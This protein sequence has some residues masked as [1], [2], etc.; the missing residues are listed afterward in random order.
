MFDSIAPHGGALKEL[1]VDEARGETLKAESLDFASASLSQRQL[2]DLELLVSGGFSPLDGFMDQET[3][4]SVLDDMRLPGGLLWPIP[5][6][7]DV[8]KKLAE[9]LEPSMR[10]ALRDNE[11]FMLGVLTVKDVWQPDKR[12]EAERVYGTSSERHAGVRFLYEQTQDYY[13]GGVVE[14]FHVATNFEYEALRHTPFELRHL[15]SKM[16]WRN[17]VAFHTSQPMHRLQ[18]ELTVRAAK[19]AQAHILLHPVVGMTKPGDLSYHTRVRCYQAIERHYPHG[20]STLSLLPLAMRMAGPREA[21]WH[22][23][24]RQNYGCTHFIV[25]NNHADPPGDDGA[26][27]TFYP[28]YEAQE[29]IATHQAQI[30]IRMVPFKELCYAPKRRQFIVREEGQA[31]EESCESISPRQLAHRLAHGEEIPDW[32]T[33]PGVLEALRKIH[34]PRSQQGITLFFTGL[35][36]AGKSTIARIMYGKFIEEG[37]RPVTLLD[38]DI[39]RQHLSSELGFSK[40]HRDLNVRRIG[41]VASEIT[42][43]GGVA[44][45]APIG[46]YA[47]TR[48]AVRE[49]IEEHGAFIEIHVAT[50]L[51]VCEAR[52]RKGLYAKARKGLIPEFTG[53]SDPYEAPETPELC[54][55]TSNLTPMQAAQEVFLYLLREGYLDTQDTAVHVTGEL[56]T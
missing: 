36:G 52:D 2:C 54:I 8:P 12:R 29:L 31:N 55:D 14:G 49:M 46:P 24:V 44:I 15:F 43:N 19:E 23:L 48:R 7:L 16:G 33:Y 28:P 17:V 11:G 53:I 9:T 10:L 30:G 22:A 37:S 27:G 13:V 38:G 39:V 4:E 25:G 47:G 6:T 20:L 51:D 5:V 1:L 26:A 40:P 56:H 34:P 3:Y 42:K 35:S 21:L 32:F 41:F 18:R 50:P 45:C